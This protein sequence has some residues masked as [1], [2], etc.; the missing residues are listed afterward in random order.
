M[1]LKKLKHNLSAVVL[2]SMA[3]FCVA[4]NTA[5]TSSS[6]SNES[7]S[8]DMFPSTL[9]VTSPLSTE[10]SSTSTGNQL[11]KMTTSSSSYVHSYTSATA[12]IELLLSGTVSSPTT[13]QFD[14]EMFLEQ[15]T[16]A[17][18]FGPAIDYEGHPDATTESPDGQLPSNDLGIWE[19]TDTS[20][21]NACTAAQLSSR[22]KS[23]QNKSNAS[24][25]GLA[26]LICTANLN[27]VAAPD[28]SNP[29]VDLTSYMIALGI[30]DTTINSATIHYD[31]TSGT[32]S[33]NLDFNYAP[34]TDSY[35]I[36]VDMEH[37]PTT[38]V[39]E[40]NGQVSY[41]V[42]DN[43]SGGN[44]P[45]SDVTYN[46]SL[47]YNSLSLTEMEVEAREA[48]FCEH[49]SDGRD[50]DGIIDPSDK[51][52]SSTNPTGWGNNF[53]IFT[54][55]FNPQDM[56][57]HYAYSW[58]AGPQDG[59]ARVFNV[60][61]ENSGNDGFAFYGYG[62]DIEDTDGSITGF[63]CN[64][65]GPGSDHSL[66]EYAQYQAVSIDLTDGSID[67]DES[68]IEYAPTVSCEYDGTGSFVFDTN[69]DG[70]L[71]DEDPTATVPN[72]LYEADDI[73]SDGDATIEETIDDFGF[74]LPVIS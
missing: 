25:M 70:D 35:D 22:M 9:A 51:Y 73:D 46:G 18:C 37:T 33:Y 66:I 20:T 41:L 40:F 69:L 29:D 21:G 30:T 38:T 45:T 6:T 10:S 13:C 48:L 74:I 57:G 56:E 7:S 72:D 54:A 71:S 11:I 59:N 17:E 49:N 43:F 36:E 61:I 42:N 4:C 62:D 27:G 1:I 14:P 31:A 64:W 15:S 63:I 68:Y 2:A 8:S 39:G 28:A 3:T 5:T 60:T 34:G 65:A 12:R 44:C 32:Y 16:N 52:D 50:A 53:N 58:Q 26:S 55:N 19:E 24:L 23:V 47:Q 67:A